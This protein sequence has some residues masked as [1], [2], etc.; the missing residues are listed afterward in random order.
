[1]PNT[2]LQQRVVR[3]LAS[4]QVLNGIGVAGTVAAGSLL[5]S[6]ITDSETLAGLAQT[7]A[8][9]GAAALALPLARLTA[10]GGR[11]LAL[12]VGY[13]CGVIGSI[14]A[15]IGGAHR[16]LFFMLLG[17]FLVGAA[18][19]AG[20]QAR[21]A[22]IDLA[23]N[24]TR[25]KQL[26]FV[27]WGSTIGAVAGPNLMDPSGNLAEL[28]NL[29]RLVGPYL[30]SATTLFLA[31]L[32]IFIFLRPDPYLLA[33]KQASVEQHK[34]STKAALTHIRSNPKALFA[35]SAIAI[36]HVAMVSVMVMTPIHM[37]HVDV[38]LRIIGFVISVHVLGMYAFSP[39]IGSLSDRLGR[40][41]VIQ[42]G[43]VILLASTIVAGSAAADNAIQLGVGL[44]LLGLG[45]SCTL[46]AGSAFLSESVSIQ[47]RP[48]SQGASDLVMN[49]AGAGGG[50]VAG[51]IIGTLSYGWL[52]LFATVPVL[53]L[54]VQSMR[55]S[56]DAD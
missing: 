52:C 46:I 37:K 33:E 55:V 36:G 21:F 13:G 53:L 11:R 43:L 49:L 50:A 31:T 51:L 41:R 22:A 10:R 16:S 26:S 6:S 28:F 39:I 44:F 54:G 3:T 34:G 25:A 4:A 9:L 18:S 29:P 24:E 38:S 35:I 47:M 32:V 42:I 40:V 2:Q 8:V 48:A 30:V 19:A 12:S 23:T 5:V 27:V 17:T 15:I 1:M 20:Y 56:R 7:S 45:W 14:F